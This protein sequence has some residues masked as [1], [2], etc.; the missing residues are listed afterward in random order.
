MAR[1][2]GSARR[3]TVPRRCRARTDGVA[4]VA[5]CSEVEQLEL[6]EHV[7][8]V[9]HEQAAHPEEQETVNGEPVHRRE[10]EA[11]GERDERA[12]QHRVEDD[13]ATRQR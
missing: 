2:V 7:R 11:A 8:H 3:D 6:V 10:R 9:T 1:P 12:V 4:E 5:P 13:R